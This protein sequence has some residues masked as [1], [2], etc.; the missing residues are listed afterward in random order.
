MD[1]CDIG[2]D[3]LALRRRLSWEGA[4][5]RDYF[6]CSPD[7]QVVRDEVFNLIKQHPFTIQATIMEKAKAQPHIRSSEE[8]F[9]Q[10]GWFFHLKH[11]SKHYLKPDTELHVTAAT[12]GTKKKRIAFED[13]VRDVCRQIIPRKQF[14]TSFW[15]C[16][17]DPCL[18]VADYCTWAIQRKWE[19]GGADTRTYDLIKDRIT[20]EFPLWAHGQVLYY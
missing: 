13:A 14:R 12:I 1:N 15:P 10:H 19:S 9:Y 11:S 20:Y 3:L 8:R 5:V 18:Q 2:H 6:H 7:K 4:P 16:E 17:T